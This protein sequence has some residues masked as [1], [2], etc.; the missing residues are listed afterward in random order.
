MRTIIFLDI[1]DVLVISRYDRD[2]LIKSVL[3]YDRNSG[4][5]DELFLSE[6]KNNL[7]TLSSEFDAKFVISSGWAK[8]FELEHFEFIFRHCGLEF[9]SDRLHTEWY[10]PRRFTSCRS[11]EIRCWMDENPLDRY[12]ILDDMDSGRDLFKSDVFD[13]VV[14]CDLNIGFVG[15]KLNEARRVLQS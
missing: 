7:Q 13:H 12:V 5:Y 1:D 9:I 6:A 4:I 8:Y 2:S 14:F 15:A 11:H 3:N 10:T